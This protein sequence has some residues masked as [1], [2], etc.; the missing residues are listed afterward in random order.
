M[1]IAICEDNLSEAAALKTKIENYMPNS[2]LITR[3]DIFECAEKLLASDEVYDL[4]VLDCKLPDIDGVEAARLYREKNR[5]A[6]IIFVTA[7]IEYAAGGYEVDALRYLLKPISNDKLSEALV[8][9][10]SSIRSDCTVEVRGLHEPFFVK[11]SEIMYI[12][13]V[14]RKTVVRLVGTSVESHKSLAVFEQ[15]IRSDA[16]FKTRRQF[17]VNMKYIRRKDGNELYM[18]NGEKVII[19]RRTLANFNRAYINYLKFYGG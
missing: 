10:E 11:S 1:Y 17:I 12:E 15:E 19:S 5:F 16:F 18:E 4:V 8:A 2:I 14:G 7:Y 9:F 6:A 3:I 13:A